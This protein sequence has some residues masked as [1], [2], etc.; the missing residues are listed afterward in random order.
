MP[1]LLQ[2]KPQQANQSSQLFEALSDQKRQF[3]YNA[4][5]RRFREQQKCLGRC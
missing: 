3:H 5:L 2:R 4:P 1:S